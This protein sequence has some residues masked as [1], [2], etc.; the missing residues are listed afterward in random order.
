MKVSAPSRAKLGGIFTYVLTVRNS[1]PS[2]ATNIVVKNALPA[3][4]TLLSVRS[5]QGICTGRRVLTCSLGRMRANRT[6]KITIKVRATARGWQRDTGSVRAKERDPRGPN[7][8][9]RVRTI[10]S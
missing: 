2:L 6:V 1:G 5:G 9:Q 8:S 3:G 4:L 7:N 10:V